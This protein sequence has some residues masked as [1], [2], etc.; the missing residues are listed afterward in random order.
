MTQ[1][2]N[3]H[4][5][6]FIYLQGKWKDKYK[7]QLLENVKDLVYSSSHDVN[8]QTCNTCPI[9]RALNEIFDPKDPGEIDMTCND[10]FSIYDIFN[11]ELGQGD[12][13]ILMSHF[14]PIPNELV[15]ILMDNDVFERKLTTVLRQMLLV[16]VV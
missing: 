5:C 11:D 15:E 2:Y 16:I 12:G 14:T 13:L 10:C 8:C 9:C 3:S 6:L 4:N 1:Y 7:D